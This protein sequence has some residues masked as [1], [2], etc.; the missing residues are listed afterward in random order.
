TVAF[1]DGGTVLARVAVN[2]AGQATLNTALAPGA[3][4]VTAVYGGDSA[5]SGSS[6]AGPAGVRGDVT[7]LVHII[8]GTVRAAGKGRFRQRVTLK[9]VSLTGIPAPLELA[10]DGL[11]HGVRLSR[12][13]GVT[14]LQKPPGS[15]VAGHDL[16]SAVVAPGA[17]ITIDMQFLAPSRSAVHFKPRVLAGAP[18]PYALPTPPCPT[19]LIGAPAYIPAP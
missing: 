1:L 11:T 6:A 10:L 15:P 7:G 12:A 16:G 19:P 5:F 13:R 9:N 8:L 14:K 18:L 3:H 2:A 4:A 17:T